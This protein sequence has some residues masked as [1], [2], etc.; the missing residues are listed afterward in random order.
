MSLSYL[1]NGRAAQGTAEAAGLQDKFW[2]MRNVLF[3]SQ[4]E[5]SSLSGSNRTDY[6]LSVAKDLE[7]DTDKFLKDLE[8]NEVSKK[9]DF[10]NSLG[11]EALV[12][13]TPSFFINGALLQLTTLQQFTDAIDAELT[14][15]G[16]DLPA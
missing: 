11:Q 7:L 14:K 10:D 12:K 3:E 16:I 9:I 6:F 5:W 15:A 2:E 8:S 1:T 4:D 13:A